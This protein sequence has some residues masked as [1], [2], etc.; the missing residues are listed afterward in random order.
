[1]L[2]KKNKNKKN[3]LC[4]LIYDW[5]NNLCHKKRLYNVTHNLYFFLNMSFWH[6]WH[7]RNNFRFFMSQKYSTFNSIFIFWNKKVV[8]S[9]VFL[10]FLILSNAFLNLQNG[11]YVCLITIIK[12]NWLKIN[13]SS[14]IQTFGFCNFCLIFIL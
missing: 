1:M 6:F 9:R 13:F 4:T 14:I 7:C 3:N 2:C 5:I 10:E 11:F 8:L 12:I